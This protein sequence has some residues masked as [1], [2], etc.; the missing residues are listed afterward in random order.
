MRNVKA[1]LEQLKAEGFEAFCFAIG[2]HKAYKMRIP[3]ED[4]FDQVVDAIELLNPTDSAVDVGGWFLRDTDQL[5]RKFRIPMGTVLPAG[6]HVWFDETN[7]FNAGM[8][9]NMTD[10][11]LDAAFGDDVWLLR[12]D[13]QSNRVAF[14]RRVKKPT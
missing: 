9:S 3:G 10:F 11:A 2:A 8:G 14:S 5:Y 6:G 12:G 4:E 7:H 13:A 1:A